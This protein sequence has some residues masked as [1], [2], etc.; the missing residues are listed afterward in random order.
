MSSTQSAYKFLLAVY[1]LACLGFFLIRT[2][3][4]TQV[5][6]PAQI[7][8]LS[9]LMDHGMAPYRDLLE[10]NMPG[11]YL[12]NWSVMHG[13]G[14][15]SAAWRVFDVALMA[16]AAWA[17]MVIAWPYD[18]LAGL[19]GTT[20]FL[21]FHG[22]DGAGQAGQRDFIIAVLLLVAYVSLFQC[23][24]RR[25]V[26]PMLVFGFCTGVASTI[27]PTPL[28]FA[29]VLLL[30]AA[31]RWK[32]QG[33]PVLRPM[34]LALLGFAL[35]VAVVAAFLAEKHSWPAF[36]YLLTVEM[37]FYR[38]LDHVGAGKMIAMLA[39]GSVKTVAL[40]ALAL[41]WLQRD[42]KNWERNVLVA[43]IAFG[44]VSYF[45]QGKAFPYHRYPM[46]AFLFLWAGLEIVPALKAQG[47]VRWLAIGGIAFALVISPMYA[48]H[49]GHKEWD[50]HFSNALAADLNQLGGS[51]LSGHV[52]CIDTPADCAATL[53]QLQLVQATGL[54]Y[55][56]LIFG[57]GQ[58]RVIR[59]QRE[60]FWEQFQKNPPEVVIV[61]IDLYPHKDGYHKLTTWPLF[62]QELADHYSLYADRKFP[63]A[64]AGNRAYRIYVRKASS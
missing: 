37:P 14:A 25:C 39:T 17:M 26:W 54:F 34:L 2:A 10:I 22:R 16:V 8:Y 59:E 27:K 43:G 19:L 15:G 4:W 44:M 28:P 7:H 46:L 35:P 21:L 42:W 1:F 55:D 23:F 58:E 60:R 53:Y 3:H 13:L 9:F 62:E 32:R 45:L 41:A 24:R 29:F 48:Y 12:V 5:N 33:E 38:V 51:Q 40:L 56:Y 6:D 52:Q 36:W 63:V 20:L 11:T 50:P 30:I 31:W 61:G 64:E 49:A 18:W 57:D 47:L